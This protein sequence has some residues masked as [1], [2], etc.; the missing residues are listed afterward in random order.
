MQHYC[1]RDLY[2]TGQLTLLNHSVFRKVKISE[3]FFTLSWNQYPCNIP[4]VALELFGNL[5]IFRSWWNEHKYNYLLAWIS[6]LKGNMSHLEKCLL[7]ECGKRG[8]P[9]EGC[10]S[11]WQE[12]SKMG[13]SWQQWTAGGA[14]LQRASTQLLLGIA[15][16]TPPLL[17]GNNKDASWFHKILE[18]KKTLKI[19]YSKLFDLPT[20][21]LP[22]NSSIRQWIATSIAN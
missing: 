3:K 5:T 8:V 11:Y 20:V 1:Q 15:E 2:F 18:F 13:L 9:T 21:I 4:H 22:F 19:I 16:W 10:C 12:G 7:N 14:T 17:V 6:V